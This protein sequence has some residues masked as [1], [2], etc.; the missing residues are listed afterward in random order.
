MF[1][2]VVLDSVLGTRRLA[3]HTVTLFLYSFRGDSNKQGKVMRVHQSRCVSSKKTF[4]GPKLR[5]I[6]LLVGTKEYNF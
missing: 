3:W 6:E 2:S 1:V 4:K 5:Q